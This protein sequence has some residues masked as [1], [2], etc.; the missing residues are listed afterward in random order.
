[1][2]FLARGMVKTEFMGTSAW[3]YLIVNLVKVPF[4][5]DLGLTNPQTLVF[6][7]M[8]IPAVT[9][10]ALVGVRIL[11]ILPQRVF[12]GIVLAIAVVASARLILAWPPIA[13]FLGA[14]WG[15]VS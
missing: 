9:A 1:V 2:F 13:A 10:G 11:P 4:S 8:M 3:F 6:A 7:A 12:N 5:A 15:H 14:L